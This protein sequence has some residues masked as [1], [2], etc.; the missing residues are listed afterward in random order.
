VGEGIIWR[1]DK[2]IEW[3]REMGGNERERE[4][5]MKIERGKEGEGGRG[6]GV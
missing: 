6:G 5:E 1:E 3:A 2:E 4:R